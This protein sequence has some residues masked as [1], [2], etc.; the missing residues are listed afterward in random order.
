MKERYFQE[1]LKTDLVEKLIANGKE[2]T[3]HDHYCNFER[4]EKYMPKITEKRV[5]LPEG[6][7]QA[8]TTQRNSYRDPVI[9]FPNIY[10]KRPDVV[11]APC[12]M[13]DAY[14]HSIKSKKVTEL[15][16]T[17]GELGRFILDN[18]MHGKIEKVHFQ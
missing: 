9:L 8:A 17:I 14:K 18:E 5:P 2:T 7:K 4:Y 16:G 11:I 13:D 15:Q 10:K 12:E 3:Y 1:P 6:W